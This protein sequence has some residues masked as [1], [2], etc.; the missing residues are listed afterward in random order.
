M[1]DNILGL[2]LAAASILFFVIELFAKEFVT[3]S[4]KKLFNFESE[5]NTLLLFNIVLL[6]ILI[7]GVFIIAVPLMKAEEAPKE[8]VIEKEI[9]PQ[10]SDAEIALEAVTYGLNEA[11]EF[12]EKNKQKNDSIK[13]N[14]EKRWVYQ[15]GDIKDNKE[16]ILSLYEKLIKINTI[17]STRIFVFKIKKNKFFIYKDDGSQEGQISKESFESF[18]SQIASVELVV[19]TID[20]MKYCKAKEQVEE[21]KSLKF[22]KQKIEIVCKQC[23]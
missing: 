1:S 7:I 11:K 12:A 4:I 21:T 5:K 16:S 10:K 2:S 3:K 20:L 23:D 9:L 15:I 19:D 17:D 8:I 14:R 18:K 6:V 22:K 13:A